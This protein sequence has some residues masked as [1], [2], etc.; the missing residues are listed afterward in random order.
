MDCS[1]VL[2][3]IQCWLGR[4]AIN[5]SS[6]LLLLQGLCLWQKAQSQIL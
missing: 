3:L 6:C 4:A 1:P 5:A 2:S